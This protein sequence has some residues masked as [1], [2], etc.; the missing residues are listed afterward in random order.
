MSRVRKSKI[1]F[2]D[3]IDLVKYS[4]KCQRKNIEEDDP[5]IEMIHTQEVT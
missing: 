1:F 3:A 4:E 5:I 2:L